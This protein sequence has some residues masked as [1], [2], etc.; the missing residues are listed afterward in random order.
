MTR[1][2][3]NQKL[4]TNVHPVLQELRKARI[5]KEIS[6][7]EAAEEIGYNK[8]QI[9]F[10]ERQ[11]RNPGFACVVD[12]ADYLGYDLVLRERRQKI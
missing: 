5:Y 6:M 1:K 10:I 12:Y 8:N 11:T 7:A 9:T 2:R 3:P 4:Y